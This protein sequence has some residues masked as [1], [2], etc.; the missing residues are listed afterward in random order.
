MQAEQKEDVGERGMKNR[1][2]VVDLCICDWL[3]KNVGVLSELS[4]YVCG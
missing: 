1:K 4:L 2:Q 3:V